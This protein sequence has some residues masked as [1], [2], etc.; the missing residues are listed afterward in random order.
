VLCELVSI[1]SGVF[2]SDEVMCV[3]FSIALEKVVRDD[4][5]SMRGNVFCKAV[6]ILACADDASKQ[7]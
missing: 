5:L 6:Q 7:H 4:S 1:E 2:E 3:V